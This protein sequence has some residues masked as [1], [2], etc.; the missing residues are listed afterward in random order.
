MSKGLDKKTLIEVLKELFSIEEEDKDDNEEK[1]SDTSKTTSKLNSDVK[2]DSD[3]SKDKTVVKEDNTDTSV[4]DN[5]E[6]KKMA[7]VKPK[8]DK[9]GM[10]DLTNVE[11]A[12]LKAFYK[13]L[14]DSRK[15]ELEQRKAEA[16]STM[17]ES[18]IAKAVGALK[19]N[20]GITADV[21]TKLLDRNNIKVSEDGKVT[22]IDE[23]VKAVQ[24]NQSGLFIANKDVSKAGSS[25]L[26]EGFNPQKAM[27]QT[28]EPN[29]FAEAF[30][31][32]EE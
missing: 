32:M 4:T 27:Q 30:A 31:S 19:L 23:A 10:I 15:A 22:G 3:V 8:I 14:N 13:E 6:G 26:L 24:T 12:E 2:N 20:K 28:A 16:D 11:D 25:P 21:V 29:S 1:D 18:E 9:N 17:I 5:K 7:F